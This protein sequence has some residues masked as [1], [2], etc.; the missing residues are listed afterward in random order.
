MSIN[1]NEIQKFL[2]AAGGAIGAIIAAVLST[3]GVLTPQE[4]MWAIAGLGILTS[5]GVYRV[6]GPAGSPSA[7]TSAKPVV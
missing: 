3:V 6:P 5:L 1:F 2:V 4:T 7:G